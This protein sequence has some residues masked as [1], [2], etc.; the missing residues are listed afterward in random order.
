MMWSEFNLWLCACWDYRLE[1]PRPAQGL[2][3]EV[4]TF[5]W[6]KIIRK[7]ISSTK[8]CINQWETNFKDIFVSIITTIILS[9]LYKIQLYGISDLSKFINSN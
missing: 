8:T 5:L 9:F 4:D 6:G 3:N 2:K 7:I 1:L